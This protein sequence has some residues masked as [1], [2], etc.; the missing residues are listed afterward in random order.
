MFKQTNLL[1]AASRLSREQY[2]YDKKAQEIKR[3]YEEWMRN[4]EKIDKKSAS[5]YIV[6][7]WP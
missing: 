7:L 4:A 6:E 2:V 5:A 3:G 1:E